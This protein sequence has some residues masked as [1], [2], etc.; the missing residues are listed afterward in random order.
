MLAMHVVEKCVGDK[1]DD[2]LDH[3]NHQYFLSLNIKCH[4][5]L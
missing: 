5:D 2:G 1:F 4:Q 3:L